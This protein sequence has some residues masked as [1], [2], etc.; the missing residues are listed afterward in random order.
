MEK[1]TGD[2]LLLAMI[3]YEKLSNNVIFKTYDKE[4]LQEI[5]LQTIETIV[6]EGYPW[7]VEYEDEN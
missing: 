2:E 5:V 7:A 3:L 6:D 1:F 4:D